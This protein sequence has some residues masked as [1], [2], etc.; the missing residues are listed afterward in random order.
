[1][2]ACRNFDVYLDAKK[3][4]FFK[5]MVKTSQTCYLEYF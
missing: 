5:D 2:P 3:L 1:M 4:T